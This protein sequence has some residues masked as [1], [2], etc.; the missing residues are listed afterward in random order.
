MVGEEG[1]LQCHRQIHKVTK[2]CETNNQ[3]L[4]KDKKY[5][6]SVSPNMKRC[7]F[8]CAYVMNLKNV[9]WTELDFDKKKWSLPID[10]E[11]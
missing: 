7:Q 2:V 9:S 10:Q 8:S 5:I 6:S 3:N 1:S 4:Y 11:R